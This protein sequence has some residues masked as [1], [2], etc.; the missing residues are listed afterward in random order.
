MR[1]RM[2]GVAR[3]GAH[4]LMWHRHIRRF[5][6]WRSQPPHPHP[7]HTHLDL[8][9]QQVEKALQRRL[10]Q[11]PHVI[12]EQPLRLTALQGGVGAA[13]LRGG[14]RT[15]DKSGASG[16]RARAVLAAQ[17]RAAGGARPWAAG[18]R[19]QTHGRAR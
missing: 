18:L 12:A 5:A 1:A 11:L 13:A 16:D 10:P 15:R 4:C 17:Q 6:L 14:G 2:E 8:A 9:V 19:A 7:P 3:C